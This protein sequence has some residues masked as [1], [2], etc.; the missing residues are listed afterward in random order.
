MLKG[1]ALIIGPPDTPYEGGY[2]LFKFIFPSDYPF[3]PP[4]ITYHTNDGVTRMQSKFIQKWKGVSLI[5]EYME[6]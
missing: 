3:S 6:R 5:I 4:K 1:N 2:Y